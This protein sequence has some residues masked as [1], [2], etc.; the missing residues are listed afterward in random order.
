MFRF[1]GSGWAN[2][3]IIVKKTVS[4]RRTV[5]PQSDADLSFS[6]DEIL[7][8]RTNARISGMGPSN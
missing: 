8:E 1:F 3:I 5:K 2:I 7:L 4:G 6:R